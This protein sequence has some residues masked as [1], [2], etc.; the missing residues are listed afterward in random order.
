M[1]CPHWDVYGKRSYNLPM[2]SKPRQAEKVEKEQKRLVNLGCGERRD[3]DF[4]TDYHV[5]RVDIRDECEPDFRADLRKLPFGKQFDVVYSS[6]VLEHFGRKETRSVLAEWTR[7]LNDDGEM[8]IVVPNIKWA[9]ENF[10]VARVDSLNVLY[11]AQSNPYDF[12]KTGFTKDILQ[13]YLEELQFNKFEWDNQNYNL[14]C[15]AW[16][17]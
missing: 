11:G 8:R 7:I 5:T 4:G 2:G 9:F 16:R 1:L 10:D 12:H 14:I 17:T 3:E 13:V 6:H 15:R